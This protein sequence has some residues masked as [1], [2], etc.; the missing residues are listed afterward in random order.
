EQG[1][2][3]AELGGERRDLRLFGHVEMT[4]RDQ[5]VRERGKLVVRNISCEH[6]G[7]FC[8]ERERRRAAAAVT[9]TRLPA[10]RP[11]IRRNCHGPN[12]AVQPSSGSGCLTNSCCPYLRSRRVEGLMI[13][14]LHHNVYRCRD[15][16]ETRVFYEDFLGLPLVSAFE[17]NAAAGRDGR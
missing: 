16:E 1:V 12:A 11:A 3:R 13:K 7:A 14:G 17:I 15:S 8:G 2:D 9:R 10:S 4:R 5:R 6:A